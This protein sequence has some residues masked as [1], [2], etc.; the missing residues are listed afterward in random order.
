MGFLDIKEAD[1]EKEERKWAAFTFLKVCIADL[2]WAAF[3][4]LDAMYYCSP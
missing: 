1:K 4:F 3:T 2:K